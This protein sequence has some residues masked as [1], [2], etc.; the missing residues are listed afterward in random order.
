METLPVDVKGV[1]QR[2]LDKQMRPPD[3]LL[4]PSGDLV[5]SLRHAQL[6]AAGASMLPRGIAASM[7][8]LLGTLMHTW[9]GE[10]LESEGIP[11]MREVK[12]GEWLPEG[13]TGTADFLFFD[14][15]SEAW[16]LADLKTAKGES[17]RYMTNSGAKTE[18]IWQASAYFY[19]LVEMG[20]P[21]LDR[22]GIIYLPKN[23]TSDGTA[24]VL[25]SDVKPLD[26]DLVWGRMEERWEDTQRY[27]DSIE[28]DSRIKLENYLTGDLAAPQERVQSLVWDNKRGIWDVKLVPHWSAAYCEFPDELC[29]C[30]TTKPNKIGHW[31]LSDDSDLT[32]LP[33]KGY[34]E[35]EPEVEPSAKQIKEKLNARDTSPS[36]S[37]SAEESDDASEGRD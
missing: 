17:I 6:R 13:W 7:P 25:I 29:D 10:A 4:H 20:L 19:A 16:V 32:Y 11:V 37:G 1:I 27:F 23:S 28:A 18:H 22:F 26:R 21:M 15:S 5:G 31:V 33:R 2:A 36:T 9:L 12:L 14:P 24:D 3:G 34:E 30:N 8:L 35:Y